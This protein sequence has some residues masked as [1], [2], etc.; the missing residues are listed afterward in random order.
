MGAWG[1]GPFSN[2]E[3]ADFVGDLADADGSEARAT[4]LRV[5][6]LP[7]DE[8]VELPDACTAIAAAALVAIRQG[9]TP[10]DGGELATTVEFEAD[11]ELRRASAMA[12]RR[13]RDADSEWAELWDEAGELPEATGVLEDIE[14]HL[15]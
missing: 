1:V 6:Q 5:L 12:L 11:P 15:V 2:D 3:A 9:Y 10:P 14:R 13:V 7:P 4:L 8:Y